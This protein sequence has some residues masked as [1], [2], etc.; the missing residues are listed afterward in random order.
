VRKKERERIIYEETRIE[1]NIL[2]KKA[3]DIITI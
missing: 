1:A 3:E 2:G